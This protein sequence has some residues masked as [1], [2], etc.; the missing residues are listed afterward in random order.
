M[1][2][3]ATLLL[4]ALAA[5]PALAADPPNFDSGAY[6]Y[7]AAGN[8]IRV[9]AD[10]YAY[11]AFGR[12]A[13]AT[14]K[15]PASPTN[16]QQFSYDPYGNATR[17]V[18]TPGPGGE[19]VFTVDTTTNR[20]TQVCFGGRCVASS[21]DA[22]GR[23]ITGSGGTFQWD[24]VGM[25]TEA[26]LPNRHEQYVYDAND[27]RIVTISATTQTRLHTLRD[28]ANKP[29][30]EVVHDDAADTW[31]WSKDYVYLGSALFA[32]Y[33]AGE[34]GTAPQ[35]HYH[36]DHLGTPRLITD[37]GGYELSR[38]TYWP[39]GQEAPGSKPEPTDRLRFTGHERDT[40]GV[41]AE[42]DLDYMHARYY[43]PSGGKFLSVDPGGWDFTRPQSLNRYVYASSNPIGRVD[44]DGRDDREIIFK[45]IYGTG[46][47]TKL[48][49]AGGGTEA[50]VEA[51]LMKLELVAKWNGKMGPS[52]VGGKVVL[53]SAEGG[54]LPK[55]P[56]F[57]I[58][59]GLQE[60]KTAASVK[61]VTDGK[62][63]VE[64]NE[65]GTGF[66]VSNEA[67]SVKVPIK[68]VPGLSVEVGLTKTAWKNFATALSVL[69]ANRYEI[70]PVV[71]GWI[72]GIR[73]LKRESEMP[74]NL[75]LLPDGRH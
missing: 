15:T 49:G 62:F 60:G 18:T 71:A 47:K 41:S 2:T 72:L 36:L 24:A 26:N 23:Q 51:D 10:W 31:K 50:V 44:P 6:Q 7:D 9:G 66:K 28:L 8:I 70:I 73:D 34:P 33:V 30:R 74:P 37:S 1:K 48:N 35:R 43:T 19:Q 40:D 45:V 69:P 59:G 25:M 21:Y 42:N 3:I 4:F 75:S 12:L 11:D 55:S 64:V 56:D 39:F 5:L 27:E 54:V 67:M 17:W 29:V 61:T 46:S 53:A 58:K 52:G 57:E 32:A 13:E 20:T 14:A 16:H 38:H 63:E 22:A 68:Q 65:G